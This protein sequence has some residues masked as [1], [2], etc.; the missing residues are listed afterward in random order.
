MNTGSKLV[1]LIKKT[2]VE[3]KSRATTPLKGQ[4]HEIFDFR[5][6]SIRRTHLRL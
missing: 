6:F 2:K 4:K 1:L 5:L 3:N